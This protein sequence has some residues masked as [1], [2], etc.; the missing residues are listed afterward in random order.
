MPRG[1][2]HEHGFARIARN[3]HN[4]AIDQTDLFGPSRRFAE[5]GQSSNPTQGG[6]IN[7]RLRGKGSSKKHYRGSAQ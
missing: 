6:G 1:V 3:E 4:V 2:S 7:R 5:K